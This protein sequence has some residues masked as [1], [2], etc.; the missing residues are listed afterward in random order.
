MPITILHDLGGFAMYICT[1]N[2]W[3]V[4]QSCI[5][6][7]VNYCHNKILPDPDW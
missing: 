6:P 7:K 1:C 4:E 3:N 2:Y 5:F